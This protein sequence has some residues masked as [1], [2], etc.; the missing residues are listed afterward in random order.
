MKTSNKVH[1]IQ[2]L[3]VG[4]F[5]EKIGRNRKM[6][7]SDMISPPMLPAANGNQKASLLSPIKNGI[8]PKM[9]ETTVKKMGK[10]FIFH[11]F[12]YACIGCIKG[13]FFLI[14]LYSFNIYM[15]A[16]TVIPHNKTKEANPPWSKF[17]SKR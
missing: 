14:E 15:L 5:R 17:S 3:R 16:F 13:C 4:L 2:I 7:N 1:K 9:V 8:K 12:T 6:P 10:T 11:A